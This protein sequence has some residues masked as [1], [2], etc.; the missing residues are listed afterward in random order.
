MKGTL[1]ALSILVL[2]ATAFAVTPSNAS[3]KGIY[4]VNYIG[5]RYNSWYAQVSCRNY[6][7]PL[8][9]GSTTSNEVEDVTITFDGKGSVT[10]SGYQYGKFDQALSNATPTWACD[11]NGNP[12][13]TNNG[14]AVY[15]APSVQSGTGTYSIQPDYTGAINLS[16]SN[17]TLILRIAGTN[18][19]G[20][21]TNFMLHGLKSD[22]TS[23]GDGFGV[24]Q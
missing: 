10:F 18:T 22:N 3:L 4:A 5:A 13:L 1:L 23:D 21:A 2:T 24:K 15:D 16:G 19:K 20:F 7:G 14:H 11:N 9:A 17:D 12:Y 6:T 8:Y